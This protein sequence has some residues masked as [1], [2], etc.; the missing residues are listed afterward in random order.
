MQT[1]LNQKQRAIIPIAA[2]TASGDLDRLTPSLEEGLNAGLTVNQIKEIL[3]QMYA[4]AGFPRSLNGLAAFMGVMEE[5]KANGCMDEIGKG[6]GPMPD[7]RN[8]LELGTEN[9]TQLVG[10]PVKGALFDFAPSIDRFLKAHLFGDIFQRDVLD[11]GERELATIAALANI[12]GVNSQLQAHYA[13]S[14]NNK[15]T[16]EQLYEFVSVLALKCGP[17]V[18]ADAEAVLEQVLKNHN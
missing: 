16:P 2:F 3:V 7:G 4:Y 9:Q 11:W 5:R 18:A 17:E 15:I 1:K 13:I 8:S 12:R 14:L 10:Q 6:A